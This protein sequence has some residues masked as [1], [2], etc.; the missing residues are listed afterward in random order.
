MAK[1]KFSYD[2]SYNELQ[3]ILSDIEQGEVSI[4]ELEVKVK[5]AR[6]LITLCQE[7]LRATEKEIAKIER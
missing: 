4:D 6:E 5:R 7:K 1:G 3:N 2:K